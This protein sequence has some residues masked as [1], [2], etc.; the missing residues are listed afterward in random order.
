M[1]VKDLKD[2]KSNLYTSLSRDLSEFEKN[3]LLVSGGI[4]AFSITFIRE[5]V[6]IEAAEHLILL[7]LSW[8]FIITAIGL[9]M[10]TFLKSSNASDILWKNVDNFIISN[11]LYD[12]ESDL[13]ND[14]ITTIKSRV[15]NIFYK[16]KNTLRIIRFG[17]VSTFIIGLIFLA[18][19][20][21]INLN[22]ENTR[23]KKDLSNNSISY[24]ISNNYQQTHNIKL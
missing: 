22:N 6:E 4:L 9:M 21:A 19:Y 20:V 10:F 23:D 1:K 15:N 3:F 24:H 2:Y 5:I 12:D 14:Q 11:E 18:F 13:E 8:G 7:Y 17:A 16:N